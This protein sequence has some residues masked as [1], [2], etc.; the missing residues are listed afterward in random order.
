MM[1]LKD[2]DKDNGHGNEAVSISVNGVTKQIHRGSQTVA[3]IKTL[4]GVALADD[5]E[6]VIDGKLTPLTDEG[7]V[8]I[9]GG[10]MFVSHPKDS[11][12]S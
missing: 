9:K 6:Q 2:K 3:E 12:S 4:G 7:R 5:L 1:E 8:T 11:G 10:E